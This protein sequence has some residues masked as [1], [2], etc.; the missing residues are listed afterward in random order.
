MKKPRE[1]YIQ[2]RPDW[3]IGRWLRIWASADPLPRDIETEEFGKTLLV[4]EVISD[5]APE[6]VGEK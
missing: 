2:E 3:Y 4:R 5:T 1:F 6:P